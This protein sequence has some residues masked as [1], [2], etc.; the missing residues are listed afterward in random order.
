MV[1]S[2]NVYRVKDRGWTYASQLDSIEDV[3]TVVIN[4]LQGRGFSLEES[5]SLSSDLTVFFK[6][7]Q[8][9]VRVIAYPSGRVAEVPRQSS[10]VNKVLARLRVFNGKA[11]KHN[12]PESCKQRYKAGGFEPRE[13]KFAESAIYAGRGQSVIFSQTKS[14]KNEGIIDTETYEKVANLNSHGYFNDKMS[15]ESVIEKLLKTNKPCAVYRQLKGK[16]G[17][18]SNQLNRLIYKLTH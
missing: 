8:Y 5:K 2:L 3:E 14:R 6:P 10:P 16:V 15:V 7:N 12:S 11:L 17:V 1:K 18:G 13:V 9:D 4:C